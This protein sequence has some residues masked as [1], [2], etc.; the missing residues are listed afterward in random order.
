[1]PEI[2]GNSKVDFD[3]SFT[4]M[5]STQETSSTVRST[6][7]F[8]SPSEPADLFMTVQRS[9]VAVGRIYDELFA[10]LRSEFISELSGFCCIAEL[11]FARDMADSIVKIITSDNLGRLTE[12]RSDTN[13]KDNLE[14]YLILSYLIYNLYTLGEGSLPNHVIK[15]DTKFQHQDVQTNS[16]LSYTLFASKAEAEAVKNYLLNKLSDLGEAFVVSSC[17]QLSPFQSNP[18]QSSSKFLRLIASLATAHSSCA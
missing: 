15:S 1:M 18:S 6:Q 3:S 14:G 8:F 4:S 17:I 9:T 13:I 10:K 5:P 12:R 7:D 2:A 11:R 16:C